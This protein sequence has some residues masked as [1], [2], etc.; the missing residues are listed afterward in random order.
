[1]AQNCEI[2]YLDKHGNRSGAY[3]NNLHLGHDNALKIYLESMANHAYTKFQ[4]AKI[5]VDQ[6]MAESKAIKAPPENVLD[7]KDN[8]YKMKDVSLE[9]ATHFL[10]ET[11]DPFVARTMAKEVVIRNRAK[12]LI[13]KDPKKF[14]LTQWKV[15]NNKFSLDDHPEAI[16]MAG[17]WAFGDH[18]KFD[19][20]LAKTIENLDEALSTDAYNKRIKKMM[21][22]WDGK[23]EL[24][25]EVHK[26]IEDFVNDYFEQEPDED[27]KRLG[28]VS[29]AKVLA[30]IPNKR[31]PHYQKLL[32]DVEKFINKIGKG[33]KLR[34]ETEVVVHD[35]KLGVAGSIDLMAF[36]E[37]NNV[38]IF[39]Y[40]TKERGK[41]WLF[42]YKKEHRKGPAKELWDNKETDG[43]LQTSLYRLMMERKGF[44]VMESRILYIEGDLVEDEATGQYYYEN[45]THKKDVHLRYHRSVLSKIFKAKGVNIDKPR[46][47]EPGKLN[48]VNELM[49]NI[50]GNNIFY[51]DSKKVKQLVESRLNDLDKDEKGEYFT[52]QITGKRQY[53]KVGATEED[54]RKVLTDYYK[55]SDQSMDSLAQEVI[56]FFNK[57]KGEWKGSGRYK[58]VAARQAEALL[59]GIDIETHTLEK[60]KNYE[61]F[62]HLSS[63]I[64][65]AIDKRDRSA[66]IINIARRDP[67]KIDIEKQIRTTRR[68]KE[69]TE[70]EKSVNMFSSKF[71]DATIERMTGMEGLPATDE[72]F[73]LL[74]AG[75][76]AMELMNSN[77]VSK[78]DAVRNGSITGFQT[79]SG[80]IQPVANIGIHTMLGHLKVLK[81][82]TG[83][84]V[85]S[86]Y[87][88]LFD[89]PKLNDPS[90]YRKNYL[91]SIYT[92]I[93]SGA[94]TM[95]KRN[96]Q[97][98]K[99]AI[100]KRYGGEIRET[101]LM[102]A[103]LEAQRVLGHSLASNSSRAASEDYRLISQAILQ[104]ANVQ[105]DTKQLFQ[106]VGFMDKVTTTSRIG[107]EAIRQLDFQVKKTKHILNL[108]FKKYKRKHDKVYDALV[109]Y[110]KSKG[111]K[112]KEVMLTLYKVDP[113]KRTAES[114][115]AN[116]T[117]LY[118]LKDPK[119]LP[120]AMADYINFFNEMIEEGF[121]HTLSDT[122]MDKL[123][124]G[125]NWTKG[126]VPLIPRS[127]ASK[128]DAEENL[129][130]KI[131]TAIGENWKRNVKNDRQTFNAINTRI[132]NRYKKQ[133]GN[134]VQH[135]RGRLGLLKLDPEGNRFEGQDYDN[136]EVNPE[137]ILNNFFNDS[138][139]IS[140][141][142]ETLGIYSAMNT[143]A[144]VEGGE[145]GERTQAL[146]EY[147]DEYVKLIVFNEVNKEKS[148]QTMDK[149]GQAMTLSALGFSPKQVLLE[150][151]TNLFA[152]S[153][154]LL[155]QQFMGKDKRFTPA[156]WAKAGAL[157]MGNAKEK[158]SK[159]DIAL[160]SAIADEFGIYKADSEAF[161]GSDYQESNKNNLFQSKW[162]YALNNLPFKFVKQQAFIAEL[163]QTGAI[164][165]MSVAED[166]GLVYDVTKDERFKD[167]FHGGKI[168]KDFN[169]EEKK[170]QKA[171]YDFLVESLDREGRLDENGMPTS[172]LTTEEAISIND[173]GRAMFGSLDSDQKV[174][175]QASSFGRMFLK[176]KNWAVAKKD[177]Y[178]TKTGK[179]DVRGER[180]WIEDPTHDNGG[181]YTWAAEDVEG[182]VQTVGY[183]MRGVSDIMRSKDSDF[184]D[185]KDRYA[186][187]NKNQKENMAKLYSDI[188]MVAILSALFG[189]L[190]DD[191]FFK[192][193]EGKLISQTLTNATNDLNI[194]GLSQ[195]MLDGNPVAAL[196]W[197]SRTLSSAADSIQYAAT[198]ELDKSGEKVLKMTGIGKSIWSVME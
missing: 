133:L 187:L 117:D 145:D 171:H 62:G 164:K 44:N 12:E 169:T 148:N 27:G 191:E 99:N 88:E 161:G 195:S 90:S 178:W 194:I 111:M 123:R 150:G 115:K 154:S 84:D 34:F 142:E 52:N 107:N 98:L 186:N 24:G 39:D 141:Y 146:R 63:D 26:V 190:F 31:K 144:Y 71:S 9:R 92:L 6:F 50:A 120:K 135:G 80:D 160:A 15:Q 11:K 38:Y 130:N 198:G 103:L 134:G 43:S 159:D 51:R 81:E 179:S 136:L 93:E 166:G 101:E 72:S 16:D 172:P 65:I 67:S 165:A 180:K 124:K 152:T 7:P 168:V 105:L 163:I 30:N 132:D 125:E 94:T 83:D 57:G 173:Y 13:H 149:M 119:G 48:T 112:P 177:N 147:M 59:K 183:L 54:K 104:I 167:I 143:I 121:S 14:G 82:F 118:V 181:Y 76:L 162:A 85:S 8:V 73:K 192:K 19:T 175:L 10:S 87:K 46:V 158:F 131:K 174:L 89:D 193:G 55:D 56:S 53:F 49:D 29:A 61:G 151:V 170:R 122:E 153:G 102:G 20:D 21:D 126:M 197:M 78:V 113:T 5:T 68:G 182:I 96:A 184:K 35:A 37:D 79:Y 60:L 77:F 28:T 18:W 155:Q 36:D 22:L 129:K 25:T 91:D 157:V 188:I 106:S 176:F 1:M 64:L 4:K 33:K 74:R 109:A 42:D 127:I 114:D 128:V 110:G 140:E 3:Y 185:F 47:M 69:K 156:A 23:T 189:M 100:T 58:D 66:K 17:E 41:E 138:L 45:L 196:S 75:V 137:T 97:A 139:R 95:R 116:V 108:K 32:L 40:K 2:V 86:F 70:N